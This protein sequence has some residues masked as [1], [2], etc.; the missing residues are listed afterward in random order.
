MATVKGTV[1]GDRVVV[2]LPF[3]IKVTKR[4][5]G[6]GNGGTG[7]TSTDKINAFAN[8]KRPVAKLL[9][10]EQAKDGDDGFIYEVKAKNGELIKHRR[11]G[12]LY[13]GKKVT[14]VFDKPETLPTGKDGKKSRGF[15]TV[16]FTVPKQVQMEDL[17]KHLKSKLGNKVIALITPDRRIDL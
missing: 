14:V 5:F 8:I 2:K 16:S 1:A 11:T 4:K 7:A 17:I 9:G 6:T 10:F 15:K 13:G 3:K 12:G